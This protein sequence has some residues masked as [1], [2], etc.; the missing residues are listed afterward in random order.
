MIANSSIVLLETANLHLEPT[1]LASHALGP[2]A[3][4]AR[5]LLLHS[6]FVSLAHTFR[7]LLQ[8]VLLINPILLLF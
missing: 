3:L 7:E 1:E 4:R 2:P 6:K 8:K 5:S